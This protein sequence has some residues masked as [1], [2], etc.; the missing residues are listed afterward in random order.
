MSDNNES[1]KSIAVGKNG[2]IMIEKI[3]KTIDFYLSHLNLSPSE[4]IELEKLSDKRKLEWLA[5]RYTLSIHM[6]GVKTSIYYDKNGK[7]YFRGM[8]NHLSISHSGDMAVVYVADQPCGI[9][10][11]KYTDKVVKVK[12]KYLNPKEASYLDKEQLEDQ[13]HVIWAAKESLYKLYG[14]G[15]LRFKE[16][17]IIDK[18]DTT[19]RRFTINGHLFIGGK[20]NTYKLEV[21]LSQNDV[22]VWTL[23]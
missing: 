17:M 19:M 14:K 23:E 21:I 9:D 20:Q 6:V 1:M 8:D 16:D 7:P 15:G 3:D 12:D 13:L 22:M 5:I 11:Q 10:I 4:N 2:L 18:F